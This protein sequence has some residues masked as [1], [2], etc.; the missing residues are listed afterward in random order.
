MNSNNF[1]MADAGDNKEGISTAICKVIFSAAFCALYGVYAF[2]NP[3]H[4]EERKDCYVESNGTICM[5]EETETSINI[6]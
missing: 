1:K 6:T 5:D 4:P 2:N 3:D